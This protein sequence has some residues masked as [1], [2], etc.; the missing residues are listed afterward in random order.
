[1]YI[2]NYQLIDAIK[3]L[4]NEIKS[5]AGKDSIK[6][7]LLFEYNPLEETNKRIC[8]YKTDGLFVDDK[9]NKNFK[10][11][12]TV[13]SKVFSSN[14]EFYAI[15]PVKQLLESLKLYD[16]NS[17][18]EISIDE[19]YKMT[20]DSMVIDTDKLEKK[21]TLRLLNHDKDDKRNFTTK[22]ICF[23]IEGCKI[24]FISQ[25]GKDN[26]IKDIFQDEERIYQTIE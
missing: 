1:M 2:H 14:D 5:H 17:M 26:L 3:K 21:K 6:N 20:K 15:V 8:L 25:E 19:N 24:N 7:Y 11:Y 13:N 4:E 16:K 22:T 12:L 10:T 9:D 23:L 18:V